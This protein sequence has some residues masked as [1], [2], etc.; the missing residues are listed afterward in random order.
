LPP[1]HSMQNR[2]IS[3]QPLANGSGRSNNPANVRIRWDQHQHG[4]RQARA[5]I[6][7]E[8]SLQHSD[9]Q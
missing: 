4:R 2:A 9:A 1:E 6:V 7:K 8:G 3:S 5:R